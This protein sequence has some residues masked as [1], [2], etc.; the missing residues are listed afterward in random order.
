MSDVQ[1]T[2]YGIERT[3]LPETGIDEAGTTAVIFVGEFDSFAEAKEHSDWLNK[4]VPEA[5]HCV[6]D[7]LVT[8]SDWEHP[9]V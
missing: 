8:A 9:D 6:V 5:T 7:R 2:Q 4:S 1:F 3:W